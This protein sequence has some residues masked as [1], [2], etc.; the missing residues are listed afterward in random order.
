M[1]LLNDTVQEIPIKLEFSSLS[2]WKWQLYVQM[3]AS[4]EMQKSFGA[5]SG[6]D[7]VCVNNSNNLV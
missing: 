3:E 6:D 7:E 5:I 2:S 1:I 4:L